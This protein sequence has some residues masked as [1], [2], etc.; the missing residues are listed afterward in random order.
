MSK[1][2]KNEII[3]VN[4]IIKDIIGEFVYFQK[5][6]I[7]Y[8]RDDSHI[9]DYNLNELSDIEILCDPDSSERLTLRALDPLYRQEYELGVKLGVVQFNEGLPDPYEFAQY[10]GAADI[11]GIINYIETFYTEIKDERYPDI[12]AQL[13]WDFGD[14]PDKKIGAPVVL[15]M[16]IEKFTFETF[17]GITWKDLD[18][19]IP[20]VPKILDSSKSRF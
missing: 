2:L 14:D 16:N 9:L 13:S 18:S 10:Y 7:K 19:L 15:D 20:S 6:S 1:K 4:V 8:W 17:R 11:P 12:G 5:I 3:P